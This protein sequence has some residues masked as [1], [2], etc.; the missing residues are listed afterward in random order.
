MKK[1]VI[2]FAISFLCFFVTDL[3]AKSYSDK[4]PAAQQNVDSDVVIY[5]TKRCGYCVRAKNFFR[6]NGVAFQV[7]DID[8]SA[9]D[10]G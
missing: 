1:I 5:V 3:F 2:C 8:K 10:L 9:E 6:A 4:K 7:I